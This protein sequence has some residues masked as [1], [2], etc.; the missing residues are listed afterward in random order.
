M[1]EA[2][3]QPIGATNIV[4]GSCRPFSSRPKVPPCFLKKEIPY[5]I[6]YVGYWSSAISY[7]QILA[8]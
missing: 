8:D 7:L 5:S 2:S 1:P 3:L 4:Q 6:K